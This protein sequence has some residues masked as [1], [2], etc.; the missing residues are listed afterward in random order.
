MTRISRAP[1]LSATRSRVSFWIT[2]ST[3]LRP[4][5]H[6]DQPPALQA[7]ERPGLADDHGVAD[8]RVVG[9]VM[10][11]QRVRDA[12]DLVVAAVTTRHIDPHGDRLVGLVGYDHA[13][14]G[15]LPAR[16]VL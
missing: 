13:L 2:A 15:L 1:V 6:F 10:G 16:A 3:S 7:R 5:H 12:H 9:L 14:A 4:L 8:V 11:V